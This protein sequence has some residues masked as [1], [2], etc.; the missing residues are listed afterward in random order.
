MEIGA[1]ELADPV[2]GTASPDITDALG[3]CGSAGHKLFRE[4]GK[5]VGWKPERGNPCI[6]QPDVQAVQ[7]F[8]GPV[9]CGSELGRVLRA[10]NELAEELPGSLRLRNF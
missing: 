4:R 1:G 9:G 2:F 8:D 5:G 7:R 3:T 6:G 10:A